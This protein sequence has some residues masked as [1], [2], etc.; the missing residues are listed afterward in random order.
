MTTVKITDLRTHIRELADEVVHHGE[1]ICVERNGEPAFAMVSIEE[2]QLLEEIEDRMDIE[3]AKKA[4]KR[5]KFTS[6][7]QAKKK[8]NL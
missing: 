4:I 6:W 1:R 3:T 5:N 2:L 7:E 8:L